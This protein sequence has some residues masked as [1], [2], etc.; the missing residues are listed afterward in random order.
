MRLKHEPTLAGS[1]AIPTIDAND[2]FSLA[3]HQMHQAMAP[4][5]IIRGIIFMGITIAYL[6]IDM[7][8]GQRTGAESDVRRQSPLAAMRKHQW[9]PL[10]SSTN[11]EALLVLLLVEEQ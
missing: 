4:L 7:I 3:L 9:T 2:Y 11:K 8:G 10:I 6:E 5:I 1:T